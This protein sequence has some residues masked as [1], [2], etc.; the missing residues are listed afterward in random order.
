MTVTINYL[1]RPSPGYT[2][3][4]AVTLHNVDAV[5]DKGPR[6][7]ELRMMFTD[8]RPTHDHVASVAVKP[9]NE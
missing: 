8:H 9:V 1:Q 7:V 2:P 4:R 6:A 3:R 5:I